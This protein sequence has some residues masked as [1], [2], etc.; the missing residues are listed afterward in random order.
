LDFATPYK[1]KVKK[2][3]LRLLSGN[4]QLGAT[5]LLVKV[6]TDCGW[7]ARYVLLSVIQELRDDQTVQSYLRHYF[8]DTL[9]D[10]AVQQA[11]QGEAKANDAY[12]S[13]LDE[14][15][16]RS[17]LYRDSDQFREAV[18]FTA[19]FR[20][21]APYNN[22]LV[23]VQ[24][25]S[26][27][28]YATARDWKTRFDR[29]VKEDARPLLILAPMHPVLLVYDLDDT[30]GKELP[31]EIRH[32]AHAEGDWNPQVL[33]YTLQNA[34]R[35]CI[36]VQLRE[37]GSQ[38]G[39]FATTRLRDSRYKM[40]IVIHS[41]LDARSCYAVLCHELAHVYLGHLG[42]DHDN[43]WP[44]RMN[45]TH[46]T[47]EIEAEAVAFIVCTRAGLTTSS[48]AY[49]ALHLKEGGVPISVSLELIVKVAG[50]LEE[51]GKR[52][53]PPRR[54]RAGQAGRER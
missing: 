33:T 2:W 52:R 27:V 9:T 17:A 10:D 43:W 51:M 46:D 50:K 26:C 13:T 34:E 16:R 28:F 4:V 47:V 1:A 5:E 37:L 44:Y 40:R 42:S 14:L 12:Q 21:Y 6:E 18:E 54:V 41:G 49:V 3:L 7:Q 53:L 15:F 24:K 20:H 23:K 8:K 25:P 11:L 22:M 39:G 38:Y 30:E 19:R 29:D 36:L 32:F 31:E 45:L 35:D 48:D